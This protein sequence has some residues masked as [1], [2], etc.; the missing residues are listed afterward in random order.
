MILEDTTLRDGE[1][2]PGIAFNKE[3]K[4][5]IYTALVSAGVKWLEVG[6]PA[7]GGEE[8]EAVQVLREKG[9]NDGV[10]TIDWNSGIK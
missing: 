9:E 4:I 5:K 1:Q 10:I 2:A 8:L 7:M 6:I 3:A